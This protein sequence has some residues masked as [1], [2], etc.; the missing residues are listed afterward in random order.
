M[1]L[2]FQCPDLYNYALL[3]LEFRDPAL[4][5][6]IID[7]RNTCEICIGLRKATDEWRIRHAELSKNVPGNGSQSYAEGDAEGG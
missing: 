4:I 6:E 3:W 7:H 1:A 2:E 5:A